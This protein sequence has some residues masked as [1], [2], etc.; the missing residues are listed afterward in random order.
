MPVEHSSFIWNALHSHSLQIEKRVYTTDDL[1]LGTGEHGHSL[2]VGVISHRYMCL[3]RCLWPSLFGALCGEAASIVSF[4][5]RARSGYCDVFGAQL[6]CTAA[7]SSQQS[8]S[9]SHACLSGFC[10]GLGCPACHL[11]SNPRIGLAGHIQDGAELTRG[12]PRWACSIASW[13]D[14]MAAA[15]HAHS[16]ANN[17]SVLGT[18]LIGTIVSLLGSVPCARRHDRLALRNGLKSR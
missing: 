6:V 18:L 17:G 14:S 7:A 15:P 11:L 1:H 5:F 8:P 16:L 4:F 3:A 2:L 9:L 13:I 12:R 10:T